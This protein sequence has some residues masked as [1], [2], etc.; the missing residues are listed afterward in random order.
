MSARIHA[1]F[2][3]LACANNSFLDDLPLCKT[4]GGRK[5]EIIQRYGFPTRRRLLYH[6]VFIMQPQASF[7]P[8]IFTCWDISYPFLHSIP[9]ALKTKLLLNNHNFQAKYHFPSPLCFSP[10]H[11][12]FLHPA[13]K[14]SPYSPFAYLQVL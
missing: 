3:D 2:I 9:M 12:P 8:H 4:S 11:T 10:S 13:P 7:N 6:L 5:V 1:F 14:S